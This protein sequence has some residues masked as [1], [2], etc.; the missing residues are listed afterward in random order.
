[1]RAYLLVLRWLLSAHAEKQ[2]YNSMEGQCLDKSAVEERAY[3]IQRKSGEFSKSRVD[4][5][6]QN[7]IRS[8]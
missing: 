5:S 8:S 1:M 3:S 2:G 6:Q 4:T 7:F